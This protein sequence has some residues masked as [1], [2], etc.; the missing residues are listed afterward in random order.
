MIGRMTLSLALV[1]A[2]AGPVSA[3][4]AS[5]TVTKAQTKPALNVIMY[6]TKTCGYCVKARQWFTSH[7]M[8]WDERDIETSA[9][10]HK[11]WEELGGVGTPFIV[12]NGKNFN[13]FMEAA[14]EAEIGK[15]R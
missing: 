7:K 12:V 11:E 2:V 8:A 15:Y 6:A 14:L 10:A 3:I 5:D 9:A 13:G 1:F 4:A